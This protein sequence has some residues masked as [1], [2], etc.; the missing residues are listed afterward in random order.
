VNLLKKTYSFFIC[1][2]LLYTSEAQKINTRL[3]PDLVKNSFSNQF[4]DIKPSWE[5]EG[6][7]YEA[8]FVQNNMHV[9]AVFNEKGQLLETE[10]EIPVSSLPVEIKSFVDTH[11]KGSMIKEAAIITN[12]GGEMIYEAAIKGKDLLFT[13][14]SVFIKEIKD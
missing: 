2:T 11:Y 9:S 14:R 13:D 7:N 5:K 12:A 6:E 8:G 4:P 1:L 10:K 3:I